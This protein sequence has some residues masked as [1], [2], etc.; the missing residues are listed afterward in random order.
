MLRLHAAIVAVVIAA[1]A[2]D[3]DDG[4]DDDDDSYV[5]I[6]ITQDVRVTRPAY[7]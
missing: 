4:G 2:D 7:L 1:T 3:D 6:P 5:C